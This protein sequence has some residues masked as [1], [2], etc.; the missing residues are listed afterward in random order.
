MGTLS[1]MR[2]ISPYVLVVIAVLFILFMVISDIDLPTI[3]SQG[4]NL[5][6]AKLGEVNG[7][8][9]MY[10]EFERRV[11]E[12]A[13]VARQQNPNQEDF[14]EAPV[15]EQVWNDMVDEILLRQEAKKLG[16]T[17][18][19]DEILDVLLE[20]PPDVLRRPF[21]DSVGRFNRDMYLEYVTNPDLIA[22]RGSAEQAANFKKYLVRIEDAI[23]LDKLQNNMRAAVGSAFGAIDP[24]YVQN[25]FTTDNSTLDADI[26]QLNANLISDSAVTV[27]AE[28]IANYYKAHE[29][30]YKQ[31]AVRKLNYAIL[32][33][34]PSQAD[35]QRV[36]KRL[37]R[38][39]G[40]LNTAQTPG[41]RDTVFERFVGD[42]GG[43]TVDYKFVQDVPPQT[44]V[45]LNNLPL[46]GVVGPI[47]TQQGTTFIRLD[48][49]R[50][51]VNAQTKASHI[52]LQ[53]GAN[54]DSAK[55]EAVRIMQEAQSGKDFN[56]L[57]KQ[58][59]KDPS[60]AQNSG[61]L[62]FFG[63]GMMVKPFEDA[64]GTAAVGSI[65]GPVE[66][67]FGWHIIKVTDRKSDE[68]K[69]SEVVLQPTISQATRSS[70]FRAA[71]SLKEQTQGGAKFLEAAQKLGIQAGET[72]FF[73]R[74]SSILGSRTLTNF[75]FEGNVGD[76]HD[77]LEIKGTG[78]VVAQI[79]QSRLAGIKPLEDAREEIRMK[80]LTS[81]K[82]DALKGKAQEVFAKVS[83]LDSL[84]KAKSV[85]STLMVVNSAGITNNGRVPQLGADV[86]LSANLF[87]QAAQAGGK[88]IGPI[89][90][91][92]GYYIAQIKGSKQADAAAFAAQ[93]TT[94]AQAERTKAMGQPFF[95][96]RNELRERSDIVDN[97]NKYFRD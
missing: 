74:I 69:Y 33:I 25:R 38:M 34:L 44:L 77:P 11:K 76:L 45:M 9:I 59:S 88:I 18:S 43:Q 15:R 75:A 17:V 24:L 49:R 67:Q 66:T 57:A 52:L 2:T 32:P 92:R 30:S 28:E 36:Q 53:F 10:A 4:Q 20:N 23:R 16:I 55:A 7:E 41:Q 95:K 54:K 31:K 82:L 63:K 58:Y 65:V 71:A 85:D 5:A 93:R 8:K 70:L 39:M 56:A 35:S 61:D 46:R 78:I 87:A 6:T 22:Q 51:G 80:L 79:A 91:E 94:L 50:S 21:T 60:A 12:Q 37:E 64:A 13:E 40:D 89:R 48:D 27:G 90:G 72:A 1:K 84:N 26:L 42:Y 14:D 29:S 73:R 3:T 96:W 62:G 97:R 86:A 83:G 68:I 19:N 81:K 47:Q